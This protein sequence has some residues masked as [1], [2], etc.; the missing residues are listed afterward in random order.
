LSAFGILHYVQDDKK[1]EVPLK[2]D[3]V[4]KSRDFAL[5]PLA[6]SKGKQSP[7]LIEEIATSPFDSAQDSSQ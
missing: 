6:E 3:L 4:R 1:K 7:V 2:R 5:R